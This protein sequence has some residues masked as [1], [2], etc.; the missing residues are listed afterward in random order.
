MRLFCEELTTFAAPDDPVGVSD[1]GGPVESLAKCFAYEGSWG[2][3]VAAFPTVDLFDELL[4]F[5]EG[6]AA[7]EDAGGAASVKLAVDH[8]EGLGS[9]GQSS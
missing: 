9:S 7:L 2:C 4:S 5:L 3:V 6:D 8:G 1:R